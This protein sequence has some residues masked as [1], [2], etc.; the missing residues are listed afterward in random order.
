M[1]STTA[2]TPKL[3]SASSAPISSTRPF[4]H[5]ASM[6]V[7]GCTPRSNNVL[8]LAASSSWLAIPPGGMCRSE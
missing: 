8:K 7:A 4:C 1:A 2:I 5:T 6:I 3:T